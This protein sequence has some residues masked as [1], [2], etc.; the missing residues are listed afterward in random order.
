MLKWG[1]SSAPRQAAADS[2]HRL[3]W[4]GV[5]RMPPPRTVRTFFTSKSNQTKTLAPSCDICWFQVTCYICGRDFGSRSIGI[6]LPSCTK[7]WEQ[8][9]IPNAPILE[10]PSDIV[11]YRSRRNY[12]RRRGGPYPPLQLTLTRLISTAIQN[13]DQYTKMFR[14]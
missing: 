7:K 4:S 1:R 12:L 2:E 13:D 3:G 8:V 14:W 5:G 9:R 10:S 6:H 11:W